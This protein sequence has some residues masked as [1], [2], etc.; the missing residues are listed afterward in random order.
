LAAKSAVDAAPEAFFYPDQYNNGVNVH[1]HYQTTGVE[2]WEQSEHKVTHFI[3]SMGTSGTFVGV[4][5]RLKDYNPNIKTIAVQPNTPFHGI[6]GTKHMLST[7]KPGI[8]D[9]HIAD[10]TV[11]VDTDSAYEIARR[12]AR[13]EGIFVGISS[14]ANV[15]AAL[16]LAKTLPENSVIV[17]ILCDSGTRY[18]SDSF[19]EEDRDD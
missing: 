4:S 6:E 18:L 11:L 1:T 19:W 5:R 17:T 15:A 9:P 13:E 16:K 3:T 2:I 14:G 12:L 7:I 10:D 8:Y